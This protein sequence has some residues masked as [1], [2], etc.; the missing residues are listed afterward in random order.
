VLVPRSNLAV[1]VLTNAYALPMDAPFNAGAFDLARILHGH[2]PSVAAAED[3]I[4]MWVLAGLLTIA[5]VLLALL[6]T[7][8]VRLGHARRRHTARSRR[9]TVVTTAAW[10][11]GCA[12][13]AAIAAWLVP[14]LW[15]A[16][17]AKVHM[18]APDIGHAIV[19]VVALA[20]VLALTRIGIGAHALSGPQR[21]RIK[22]R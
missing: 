14:T 13:A 4:F 8:L 19:A 1:L 18:W 6:V 17:L 16:S 3:P 15:G 20:G 22:A 12:L 21:S 5:A 10:I 9:R 7:T 11:S 2:A